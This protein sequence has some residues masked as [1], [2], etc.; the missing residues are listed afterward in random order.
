[1]GDLNIHLYD[2]EEKG[3]ELIC[4]WCKEPHAVAIQGSYWCRPRH[5]REG[6]DHRF[7]A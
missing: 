2:P 5:Y 4:N 6:R 3:D 7:R 1:M